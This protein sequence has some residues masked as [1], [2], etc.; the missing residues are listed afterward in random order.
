MNNVRFPE[1]GPSNQ[2]VQ[3]PKSSEKYSSSKTH[4]PTSNKIVKKTGQ[5]VDNPNPS[6]KDVAVSKIQ[7]SKS[8]P[9]IQRKIVLNQRLQPN[10]SAKKIGRQILIGT[11][12]DKYANLNTEER[13]LEKKIAI[14]KDL[15]AANQE[16]KAKYGDAIP[17]IEMSKAQRL[18]LRENC[19]FAEC[20][21]ANIRVLEEKL[22]LD[23]YNTELQTRLDSVKAIENNFRPTLYSAYILLAKLDI[24]AFKTNLK[25]DSLDPETRQAINS[26]I[27]NAQTSIAEYTRLKTT[28]LTTEKAQATI[29]IAS[30]FDTH[31]KA[32]VSEQSTQRSRL[33]T[34]YI[35]L[36]GK[37]LTP[38]KPAMFKSQVQDP[39]REDP[40]SQPET[41]L[42]AN[43]QNI[44]KKTSQSS[45][46][47]IASSPKPPVMLETIQTET[48][49]SASTDTFVRDLF[50]SIEQSYHST[51]DKASATVR[52]VEIMA[53]NG[54]V[55]KGEVVRKPSI[56]NQIKSRT[57]SILTGSNVAPKN[58]KLT[59]HGT[60]TAARE[61]LGRGKDAALELVQDIKSRL[62]SNIDSE[63]IKY[64]NAKL[65]Y[66]ETMH[67]GYDKSLEVLNSSTWAQ[68]VD[69]LEDPSSSKQD[70]ASI[71]KDIQSS[72]INVQTDILNLTA[73]SKE[74]VADI[75]VDK[76]KELGIKEKELILNTDLASTL[77]LEDLRNQKK[78]ILKAIVNNAI[79]NTSGN[80]QLEESADTHPERVAIEIASLDKLNRL[81]PDLRKHTDILRN[82]FN[83]RGAS[84]D[85]QGLKSYSD[86]VMALESAYLLQ[87]E[88]DSLVQTQ[89][90][91]KAARADKAVIDA[92]YD[93]LESLRVLLHTATTENSKVM[94]NKKDQKF[95]IVGRGNG[96]IGV[97]GSSKEAF[98]TFN[99]ML[100]KL[101]DLP[102]ELKILDVARIITQNLEADNRFL[103]AMN[104]P[105]LQ[106]KLI[107]VKD[108]IQESDNQRKLRSTSTV[109][110]N[111]INKTGVS[112][113]AA[114]P[115]TDEITERLFK[116][117]VDRD[118]QNHFLS[119]YR[120]LGSSLALAD[121]GNK[122]VLQGDKKPM[123]VNTEGLP[124][125]GDSNQHL[126]TFFNNNF[127]TAQSL[128]EKQQILVLAQQWVEDSF[129]NSYQVS[130]VQEPINELITLAKND[131]SPTLAVLSD[132]LSHTLQQALT[133]QNTKVEFRNAGTK[134][135]NSLINDIRS[136]NLKP[137]DPQYQL[138]VREYAASFTA[139]STALFKNITSAELQLSWTK[140]D[141]QEVAPNV[142]ASTEL[143]NKNSEFIGRAIL[144]KPIDSPLDPEAMKTRQ[145]EA[146]NMIEFCI[147]LQKEFLRVKENGEGIV[148]LNGFMMIDSALKKDEI[149]RLANE[150]NHQSE[151]FDGL[152]D[153]A[154]NY[155]NMRRKWEE[156]SNN[157][158]PFVPYL[159]MILSDIVF[160]MDGKEKLILQRDTN[161]YKVTSTFANF[162]GKSIYNLRTMINKA[163]VVENDNSKA[164]DLSATS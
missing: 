38:L 46:Q 1:P 42:A 115:V 92:K 58:I 160:S 24:A 85:S 28:L 108:Q 59:N 162:G 36:N 7:Q 107:I 139:Q 79:Q 29:V 105:V 27:E 40:G 141:K 126:F 77:L 64:L 20:T 145:K 119:S 22:I 132:K 138:S 5:S 16:L 6:I 80:S 88:V 90:Q 125:S 55:L 116:V 43:I 51:F 128:N 96:L 12:R 2:Y 95:E 144:G 140:K 86:A 32:Q 75:L 150:I 68:A 33:G 48:I 146:A 56:G 73:T 163:L 54:G 4:Y 147:N 8:Q 34:P 114:N 14:Y 49:Q 94:W 152:A 63:T 31:P 25:D 151:S 21:K 41:G 158:T 120:M 70:Y 44:A 131:G 149:H 129:L 101:S 78:E 9:E 127:R 117:P 45:L 23:P 157:N 148:D 82:S 124:V 154:K 30:P 103:S 47:V 83:N 122:I 123:V 102:P 100:D 137:E 136:G 81:D 66:Y 50:D 130:G 53:N 121:S 67:S 134:D 71:L 62:D 84:L 153:P 26:Q 161:T 133:V 104:R 35:P 118:F 87:Q 10:P 99:A 112:A 143:F 155:V 65:A 91:N 13:N 89:L 57:L 106:Q 111:Q 97:E 61:S 19:A 18:K 15:K 109:K 76:M 93:E 69:L 135:P 159:G 3:N 60:L 72:G 17:E 52:Q 74:S 142:L 39:R 156:L 11:T 110:S 37:N 113:Q 98:N 164:Y